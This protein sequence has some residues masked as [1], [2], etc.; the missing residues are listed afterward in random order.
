MSQGH[1]STVVI[2]GRD[3]ELFGE[4]LLI[5]DPAVVSTRFEGFGQFCKQWIGSDDVDLT[6]DAVIDL[7]EVGECGPEG[8]ADGLFAEADSQ[9]AFAGGVFPN[10]G[11]QQS[12]F[13]GNTGS[14]GEH[15]LV[16]VGDLFQRDLVVAGNRDLIDT[17]FAQQLYDVYV[18]ES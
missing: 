8:F 18:K 12:S 15:N 17:C 16:K 11:K 5:D 14:G 10:Q 2:F 3:F 13:G 4:V 1:D 7:F 6:G 9:N